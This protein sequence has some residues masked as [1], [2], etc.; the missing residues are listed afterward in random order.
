MNASGLPFRTQN[1]AL[2]ELLNGAASEEMD[3]RVLRQHQQTHS[4]VGSAEDGVRGAMMLRSSGV[5]N[6]ESSNSGS[7]VIN[8]APS[9]TSAVSSHNTQ[10]GFS[11]ANQSAVAAA[12]WSAMVHDA[13]S[14][15]D[16]S[17]GDDSN[18]NRKRRQITEASR[19]IKRC[20]VNSHHE[21]HDTALTLVQASMM[22]GG[23]QGNQYSEVVGGFPATL[24]TT[25]TNTHESIDISAAALTPGALNVQLP[26]SLHAADY[27]EPHYG[28]NNHPP[29]PPRYNQN[30]WG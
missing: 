16:V 1:P 28:Q 30:N 25:P 23:Q 21:H 6:N 13:L 24:L 18:R 17:Y 10:N 3:S 29:S 5:A 20:L 27:S 4:L 19:T 11:P 7:M 2:A 8:T 15:V 12:Q 22:I 14:S 9:S 26:I